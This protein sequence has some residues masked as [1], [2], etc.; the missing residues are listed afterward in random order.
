MTLES[1]RLLFALL[2][3]AANAAVVVGL[4]LL[5]GGRFSEGLASARDSIAASISG[6]EVWFA[7]VVALVSTL[8]SL[9]FSEIAHFEPC[10]LCWYQRIAMYP[11]VPILGVAA[12]RRDP[13][14]AWYAVPLAVIGGAIAVWHYTIQ[15]F[16][17]LSSGS[18]SIEVPCNAAYVWEFN[19]V[20]IPYMAMSG[21]ALILLLVAAARRHMSATHDS[22][23]EALNI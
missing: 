18:C 9:Y 14:V 7:F 4:I 13:D 11:L 3:L 5:V 12:W 17:D 2:A 16:P 20:S 15:Q 21:F 8:G 23:A 1:M 22:A 19:F 10:R 6:R